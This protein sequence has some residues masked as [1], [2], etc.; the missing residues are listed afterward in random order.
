MKLDDVDQASRGLNE[1][2]DQDVTGTGQT[3]NG[4]S[5]TTG[6]FNPSP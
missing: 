4:M 2:T 5:K 3:V 6:T 1:Q